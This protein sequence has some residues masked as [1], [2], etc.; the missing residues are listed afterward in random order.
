MAPILFDDALE[1]LFVNQL[2]VFGDLKNQPLGGKAKALGGLQGGADAGGRL[3]DGIG[4]EIDAQIA[5]HLQL[6]GELYRLD[7]ATLIKLV[8]IAFVDLA[9][10]LQ[11]AAAA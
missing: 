8:A 2:F 4:H 5:R 10:H 9:Q 1:V 6:R 11:G 7:A 3:I